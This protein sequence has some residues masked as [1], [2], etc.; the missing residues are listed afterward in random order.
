MLQCNALRGA[1]EKQA[2]RRGFRGDKYVLEYDHTLVSSH[3]QGDSWQEIV[4]TPAPFNSN[5]DGFGGI[6]TGDY[7]GLAVGGCHAYPC[8]MS[9]QN[10][11]P[12]VFAHTIV[13]IRPGDLD[14]DGDVDLSDLSEL[15]AHYDTCVG[16][17]YYDPAADLDDSGCVDLSDLGM[18]LAVYGTVCE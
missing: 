13:N 6:F 11:M 10:G 12:D 4:L 16:E 18:L 5:T 1:T 15:L 8:Y 3:D 14:A 2:V 17:P 9:T 7:L